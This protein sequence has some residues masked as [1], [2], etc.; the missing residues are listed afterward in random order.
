[1]T[2]TGQR[3]QSMSGEPTQST[4]R[5]AVLPPRL[6]PDTAPPSGVGGSASFNWDERLN[7]MH[8]ENIDGDKKTSSRRKSLLGKAGP[9]RERKKRYDTPPFLMREIP[10]GKSG[11]C[12]EA[13]PHADTRQTS[14]VITTLKTQKVTTVVCLRRRKIVCSSRTMSRNGQLML[15]RQK[16]ISGPEDRLFCLYM[17]RSTTWRKCPSIARILLMQHLT[18]LLVPALSTGLLPISRRTA[19]HQHRSLRMQE[20]KRPRGRTSRNG[21]MLC[22]QE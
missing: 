6:P 11:P 13:D 10:Y 7:W 14:G 2:T 16:A 3:T 9:T 17:N 8:N 12:I 18:A 20:V 15:P 22:L 5:V 4:V 1:M 19:R 21:R